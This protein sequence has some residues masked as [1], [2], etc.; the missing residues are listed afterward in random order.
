MV[1]KRQIVPEA[2]HRD[3]SLA[4][5]SQ[6]V[7]RL[8]RAQDR[9]RR[10][11]IGGARPGFQ[12]LAGIVV[13]CGVLVAD[14]QWLAEADHDDPDPGSAAVRLHCAVIDLAMV[15]P[16]MTINDALGWLMA[17]CV[18]ESSRG[19]APAT[20][21]AWTKAGLRG[22]DWLWFAAGFS[23]QQALTQAQAGAVD[24]DTLRMMAALRGVHLPA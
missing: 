1:A 16:T 20:V 24:V 9:K 12:D 2:K 15:C 14:L 18:P 3:G 11:G 19:D 21:Q 6:T 4:N 8:E 7:F 13:R 5:W 10:L 23:V 17:H 22:A